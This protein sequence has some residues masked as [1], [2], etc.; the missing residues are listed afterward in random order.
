[1]SDTATA[2][3]DFVDRL[4]KLRRAAG[5]PSLPDLRKLSER[6]ACR[7]NGWRVLAES[8]AHDILTGKRHRLPGWPWVLA[9]VRACHAAAEQGGIDP[10]RLGSLEDWHRIWIAAGDA[11]QPAR[12]ATP[13]P[14]AGQAAP[15]VPGHGAAQPTVIAPPPPRTRTHAAE[16]TPAYL[17]EFGPAAQ[18]SETLNRYLRGFGLLGG[19]LLTRA[20]GGDEHAAYCLGV[21]LSCDGHPVEGLA[22]LERAAREGVSQAAHLCGHRDITVVA[23]AAYLL[24]K[25]SE[26]A[27]D[28]AA[29]LIYYECA[30]KRGHAEAAYLTGA[31][32]TSAGDRWTAGYWLARA[33]SLGHPDAD[34]HLDDILDEV[35][36]DINTPP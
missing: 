36:G 21:L 32:L 30:A 6:L 10:A 33:A 25:D 12:A 24:G 26:Q 28:M 7:A 23:D 34:Q 17:I 27:G 1:M 9:Y 16:D 11:A 31:R 14:A 15:E 22:W 29:A 2:V 3:R 4:A 5:Q 13:G 8:T 20:E 18:R 35:R 19:R